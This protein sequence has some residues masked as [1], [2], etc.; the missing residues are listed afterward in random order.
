VV[1]PLILWLAFFGG[2][3]LASR[4]RMHPDRHRPDAVDGSTGAQADPHAAVPTP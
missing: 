1:F 3:L 2:Y 4:H